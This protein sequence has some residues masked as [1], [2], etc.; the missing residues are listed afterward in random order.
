VTAETPMELLL[1]GQ[2]EFAGLIDDVPEFA[3]KLLAG[4]ARRVRQQD[5]QTV[6]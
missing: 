1:L 4:L 6:Q 3:H 2:R 5:S